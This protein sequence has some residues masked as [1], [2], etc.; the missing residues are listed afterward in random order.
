M[1]PNPFMPLPPPS[2]AANPDLSLTKRLIEGS[3]DC[4]KVL[5]L[6][7]RL[8]SMNAGGMD[9]LEICDLSPFIGAS[10]I[11]FWRGSDREAAS[12][13]VEAA[14]EGGIGRFVGFFPTTQTRKPMWFDVMI[15]P[16]AD[17]SG[18]PEKLLAVSRDVTAWK[19]SDQLLHAIIDGTSSGTGQEFFRSLVEHL[20]KGLGVRYSFIAE[21]VPNH[22]ARSLAFWAGDKAGPDFEYDLRGTPCLKVSEGRTCHYESDLQQLFPDDEPLAEMRAKSY[23][24][25]PL[26]DSENYVIGHL[27]IIDEKPMAADSLL[28]SVMETFALRA[29]AELERTRAYEQLQRR[30]AESEERFRDLFEEAP[31]AYVY[32]GLDSKF[33]RANRAAMKSLGISPEDV[34]TTYGKSFVPDTPEAQQ[35]LRLAF[36]SIGRGIDTSGVVLELRRKDNGKPL[37]IQWWS[38]P[39]PSGTCTRTM[40]VDITERVLMEREKARLE[41]QN[42]YLQDE[43]RSEHNFNEIIGTSPALLNLLRQVE[44]ISRIDSTVL[45]LGETGTG[46]ELIA[47]AIHDRSPRRN[48][49]LVKVNC[50]AISAGLVESELFGHVKGAFTGAIAN[51]DGRFQLADGGTI[52]LDEIG[53]LPLD[54]QV[55]LLRVLQEQEFEPIGSSRTIRVNVRVVAATNRDL[56]EMVREGR[57]RAD[58]YYRLNVLPL[59]VPALRERP[60]DLP[61]LVAFFVQKCAEKIGKP[62]R[63]VSE[64]SMHRLA[65][66]SWPGNIRELQNVIERAVILSPGDTLV[67]ADEL[68]TTPAA[69]APMTAPKSKPT[70]TILPPPSN[71]GSLDEVERRHIESVLNQV[72]WIIEGERG[73][74]RILNMNPSTLR[75]RMQKL[76]INRPSRPSA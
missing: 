21:C 69:A 64:E 45:I 57:F 33:I 4:I 48:R 22:R 15:S 59:R 3:P 39:D 10:W 53:E 40:F 43:I 47:R 71:A 1:N 5:D 50:G 28:L 6:D 52:F 24:G 30:H 55:K 72:N 34:Q 42:Q 19:R 70:E 31:I 56:E 35:R 76:G 32:E 8:L 68:R 41:A 36:E 11:D 29:G 75:S 63:S 26:R 9:V 67:L 23:L 7:G 17:A 74:A 46:K 61:L 65:N 25:I 38:R 37:W 13:A 58:L 12:A 62:I 18:K 51:R 44:Q 27:V 16:I 60:V 73:A 20:A 54:T 49:A 66:Y 2:P 14:R